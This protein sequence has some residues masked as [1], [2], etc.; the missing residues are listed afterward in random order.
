MKNQIIEKKKAARELAPLIMKLNRKISEIVNR[1]IDLDVFVD[2]DEKLLGKHSVVRV[3]YLSV[4]SR[5]KEI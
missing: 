1:G 2:K 5:V 3:D 4:V